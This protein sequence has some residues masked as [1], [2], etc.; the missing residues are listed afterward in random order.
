MRSVIYR[1]RLYIYYLIK[2]K[3]RYYIH[4]PFVYDFCRFVLLKKTTSKNK[5]TID[6]IKSYYHNHNLPLELEELGAGKKTTYVISTS[7]YL[8]RTAVTDKY[9][10]LLQHIIEYYKIECVIETGTALGISAAW[11]AQAN[12]SPQ[13]HTI[14]GNRDLCTAAEKMFSNFNLNKVHTYHGTIIQTL[15]KL[16]SLIGDKTMI[17]LD[18][19]HTGE[20]SIE[21]FNMLKPFLRKDS[22]LVL[23]DINYSKDMHQAWKEIISDSSVTLSINLFR[24]GVIFFNPALS[25]QEFYLYY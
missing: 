19:H 11:M 4:S 12:T 18:A 15:P 22:V 8:T 21:Y 16:Y 17:Y 6:E 25:K 10:S 20:A 13:I 7:D 1:I 9:G 14:D 24:M 5:Q 23:D 2:G 3:S